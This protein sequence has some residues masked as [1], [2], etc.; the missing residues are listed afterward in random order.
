LVGRLEGRG[1]VVRSKGADDARATIVC[2]T[3]AGT[4]LIDRAIAVHARVVEETLT[5]RF[6]AAERAGLLE[7]LSR[8]GG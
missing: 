1:L 4:A 2:L 5:G 6:S 8:I 3:E 7:T